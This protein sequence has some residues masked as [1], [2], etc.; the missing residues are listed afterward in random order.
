MLML[1]MKKK[2]SRWFL[3]PSVI[4]ECFRACCADARLVES[5]TI[6]IDLHHM[7]DL[8]L[9]VLSKGG[10]ELFYQYT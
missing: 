7:C 5:Q 4:R 1:K 9:L 6:H 10:S 2:Q 8:L 3:H